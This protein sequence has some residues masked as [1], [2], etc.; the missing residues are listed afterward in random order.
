M[1]FYVKYVKDDNTV[2]VEL[3]DCLSRRDA[4]KKLDDFRKLSDDGQV[5]LTSQEFTLAQWQK[6][7]RQEAEITPKNGS[8]R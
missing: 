6:L 4:V 1:P 2:V 7:V 8:E 3:Q 5:S